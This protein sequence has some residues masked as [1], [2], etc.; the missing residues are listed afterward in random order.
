MEQHKTQ[1]ELAKFI[2]VRQNTVSDWL[3]RNKSPSSSYVY[4]ICDFFGVS[5]NYLFTGQDENKKLQELSEG[6]REM[7]ELI[8][9]LSPKEQQRL[10][11]VVESYLDKRDIPRITRTHAEKSSSFSDEKFC[12]EFNE[13]FTETLAVIKKLAA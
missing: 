4:R 9:P 11:G 3:N 7:L 13:H 5:F 6:E 2:G 10:I 12:K 8:H 1:A